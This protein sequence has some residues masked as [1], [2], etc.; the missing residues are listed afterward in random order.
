[1]DKELYIE[2]LY[3][4]TPIIEESNRESNFIHEYPK[5]LNS[6]ICNYLIEF[7]EKFNGTKWQRK[8]AIFDGQVDVKI[9]NSTDMNIY[10]QEF[11]PI[12]RRVD[13][14]KEVEGE[15]VTLG[16]VK[17]LSFEESIKHFKIV[18]ILNEQFLEK[19]QEYA[20]KYGQVTTNPEIYSKDGDN[21]E[22]SMYTG[23]YIERECS[24]AGKE[25]PSYAYIRPPSWMTPLL[26]KRYN[27]PDEGFHTFHQDW[28]SGLE[29]TARRE[30]VGQ[31]FLNDVDEGGET[32]FYF[33]KLKVKPEQGKLIVFP[34]YFT[35]AHKGHI[36]IS[37]SKYILTSWAIPQ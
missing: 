9:K 12:T 26:M 16:W 7:F 17:D 15:T 36:P 4:T 2:S 28:A 32:E 37:N 19:F 18:D 29:N 5:V 22:A 20:R 25:P 27:P 8:G 31:F 3:G 33:Q 24:H 13:D 1:M 21:D 34:A 35:H 23:E 11:R 14:D 30:L 6:E 10:P